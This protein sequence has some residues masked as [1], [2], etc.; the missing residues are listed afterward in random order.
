M[1]TDLEKHMKRLTDDIE[2]I[3]IPDGPLKRKDIAKLSNSQIACVKHS[4]GFFIHIRK[5]FMV[6]AVLNIPVV[7][8]SYDK[9]IVSDQLMGRHGVEYNAGDMAE[10][11]NGLLGY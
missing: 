3:V 10:Y 1:K 11:V 6:E 8:Y 4:K 9:F 7:F 5:S 2:Y